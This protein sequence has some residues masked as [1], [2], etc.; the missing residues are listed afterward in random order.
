[1]LVKQFENNDQKVEIQYK[2]VVKPEGNV[3]A[4]DMVNIVFEPRD[5]WWRGLGVL[6]NSGLKIRKEFAQFDAEKIFDVEIE[7][8]REDKGCICG[9]I[10]KGVKKPKD[11]K[12][13][14]NK[15]IPSDP[16]G[17]CMVSHE[18]SCYAHYRYNQ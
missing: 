4:Q 15:C 14:G 9:L 11:C 1:M 5:D 2:R 10:L 13:F 7:K 16:V 6:K 18:G 12:L 3:K 8:T 17:A